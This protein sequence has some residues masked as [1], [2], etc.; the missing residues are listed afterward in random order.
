MEERENTILELYNVGFGILGCS[1]D[2]NGLFFRDFPLK[3]T[4]S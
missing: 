3:L 1:N 2:Y 4:S